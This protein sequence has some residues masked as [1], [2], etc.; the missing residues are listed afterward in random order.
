MLG[1]ARHKSIHRGFN[2]AISRKSPQ[3][4]D[5]AILLNAAPKPVRSSTAFTALT[6]RLTFSTRGNRN[7]T[8]WTL[9]KKDA[10]EI[11][12]IGG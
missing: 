5:T 7:P 12:R 8:F 10:K 11:L 2:S 4:I 9:P 3:G 6:S 1:E